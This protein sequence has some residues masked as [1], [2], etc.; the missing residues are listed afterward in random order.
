MELSMNQTQQ[1]DSADK[2]KMKR[3]LEEKEAELKKMQEIMKK[4]QAEM[5]LNSSK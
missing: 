5:S 4:M 3:I 2:D 1:G